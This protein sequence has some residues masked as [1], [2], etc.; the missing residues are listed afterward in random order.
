MCYTCL[1][2]ALRIN[3]GC[4]YF[5]VNS[6]WK[7]SALE[8]IVGKLNI[9]FRK[10]DALV[11]CAGLRPIVGAQNLKQKPGWFATA[12]QRKHLDVHGL[13]F[14]KFTAIP[15]SAEEIQTATLNSARNGVWK[16]TVRITAE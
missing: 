4:C 11:V 15:T 10:M 14:A 5:V 7:T 2:G 1:F 12:N 6:V 3:L 8:N 9:S 16:Y 13:T